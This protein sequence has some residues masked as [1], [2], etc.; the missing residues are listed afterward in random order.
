L[1]LGLGATDP[2][3]TGLDARGLGAIGLG[4]TAGSCWFWSWCYIY[5]YLVLVLLIL[6]LLVLMLEVLVLSPLVLLHD[7]VGTGLGAIVIA[8]VQWRH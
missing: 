5:C 2:L 1:L 8:L 4:A 7:P 6:L 3:A